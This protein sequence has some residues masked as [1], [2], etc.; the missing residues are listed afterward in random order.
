MRKVVYVGI[1]FVLLLVLGHWS[2]NQPERDAR[3]AA[4]E[5]L[6]LAFEGSFVDVGEVS[7]HVVFAGPEDGP[8]VLLLHGFPEF[9]Y[10]WRGPAAVLARAGFRV[11]MPD[12]RGYNRSDKPAGLSEYR[13]DK[14]VADVV[15]LIDALG[16]ERVQL[17]VQDWGGV[18]GWRTVIEHPERIERFA[19][20]DASHPLANRSGDADTISWYRTFMQIPL[21]PAYS[22]RL[23]NWRLL[24]SNLRATSAPGAFPEEEMNQYRAAWDREGAIGTM[25]DWYR[26][27]A[28][29][30]EGS[31]LVA[32]PTLV[33]LADDDR[34]IPAA[35]TRA[36]LEYLENG[37]LLELGSGSHWVVGEESERIGRILAEFFEETVET[38]TARHRE[39]GPGGL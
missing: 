33:I 29:P 27:E 24:A 22:A 18:V 11:I 15:G 34:F 6:G 35:A 30:L 13:L 12:Q 9:W 32:T 7:L 19:V 26:A 17:G 10:A 3:A 2:G 39:S 25:G 20:V 36:S 28:W 8:P 16:H 4:S 31:G 14:L 37:E 38:E 5:E 21:L 23:A 1:V